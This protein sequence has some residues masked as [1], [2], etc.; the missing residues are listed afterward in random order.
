MTLKSGWPMLA[1]MLPACSSP[2]ERPQPLAAVAEQRL[3]D[4]GPAPGPA[5]GA[6]QENG[7]SVDD[8]LIAT[9][10]AIQL[11]ELIKWVNAQAVIGS[12]SVEN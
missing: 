2:G 9:E 5:G 10:Q 11:D 6:A 3:P 7:F 8:A 4:A 1:L 12:E